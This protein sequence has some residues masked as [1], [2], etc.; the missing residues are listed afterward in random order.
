MDLSSPGI[1]PVR[2]K[3]AMKEIVRDMD[4]PFKVVCTKEERMILIKV[5]VATSLEE[6]ESV[7]KSIVLVPRV[8]LQ[9]SLSK[10]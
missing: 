8:G 3:K 10:L 6:L 2:F 9:S 7:V 5:S 1:I 4:I